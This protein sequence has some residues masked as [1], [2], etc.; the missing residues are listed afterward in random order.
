MRSRWKTVGRERAMVLT[1]SA[2]QLAATPSQAP[3][4]A[5]GD[6]F[7]ATVLMVPD[8]DGDK[9]SDLIICDTAN[10]VHGWASG[11]AWLIGSRSRA[12]IWRI[13]GKRE[14]QSL[15][16]SVCVLDDMDG[17]GV[18]EVA[19][20][21]VAQFSYDDAF[22]FYNDGLEGMVYVV[23][24]ST[25]KLIQEIASERPGDRFGLSLCLVADVDHDGVRDLLVGAPGSLARKKKT[26]EDLTGHV[27][28][29][30]GK[31]LKPLA[32]INSP[33]PGAPFGYFLASSSSMRR[34]NDFL[35]STVDRNGTAMGGAQV[36]SIDKQAKV[37][38]L[39]SGGTNLSGA[40]GAPIADIDGDGVC[41]V[42]VGTPSHGGGRTSKRENG[43][44]QVVSGKDG[45]LLWEAVGS[46]DTSSFA[47]AC[48]TW[49]D[50][51]GD[52]I[53]EVLVSDF[54]PELRSQDGVVTCF[55]GAHGKSLWSIRG[56]ACFGVAISAA[57]D[58]DGDGVADVAVGTASPTA[59]DD[60]GIVKVF[61]GVTRQVVASFSKREISSRK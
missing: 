15:G 43:Y 41:D 8:V 39:S 4:A 5:D 22:Q 16:T 9:A 19:L 31:T 7:G 25:G 23:S 27:L 40:C 42:G 51:D 20:G 35:V 47:D 46:R 28:C 13:D 58:F 61:S 1:M 11:S 18:A 3:T 37:S 53:P 54:N 10:S 36:W 38:E 48:A 12:P 6:H 32:S 50:S 60:A 29:F 44:F 30:S 33:S 26:V 52:G 14:G 59:I 55:S 34:G 57:G 45:K 49:P 56:G 17:D 2:I 21:G 24:G